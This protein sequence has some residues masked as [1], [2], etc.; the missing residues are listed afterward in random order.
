MPEL[1]EVET[2]RSG[3]APHVTGRRIADVSVLHPR[4]VRRH[5]GGATD[6]ENRLRGK[7][8]DAVERRGKY[9]WLTGAD[10]SDEVA[11][12]VHLGMSGQLLISDPDVPHQKHLR[13]RVTLDDGREV[14]FV[15]QRTF[16]GW[17]VDDLVAVGGRDLPESVA[18]IAPDP[19]EDAFDPDRVVGV[20][21]RKET[22]V[23]RAILDQTVV[24]GIGNI[25]ADESLWRARVHGAQ[26][27]NRTSM[28]RLR[29]VL[30]AA[31]EVMAAAVEVGGTSFD[32]LYVNVNGQSG[33]F[34]RSL[35]AYGREGE[36][37]RRC[38]TPIRRAS[39]MNRS[40]YFCPVCQRRR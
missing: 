37:C 40:S 32:A 25:Y 5:V 22:E 16:G 30:D 23:K 7:R 8:L 20:L 36:P 26:K 39:F 29:G 15:D 11:V 24:S 4:A 14:R 3:L 18:H 10:A 21:R 9:L 12:V 13:I 33:Y 31:S 28:P 17:H 27:T 19:F 38:E 34:D 2:I 6:L 35:D 1:P